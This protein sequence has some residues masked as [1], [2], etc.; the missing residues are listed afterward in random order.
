MYILRNNYVSFRLSD[1]LLSR[2]KSISKLTQRNSLSVPFPYN[3]I[4]TVSPVT[5]LIGKLMINL[6]TVKN[7]FRSC[8]F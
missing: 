4:K 1:I 8:L 5:E 3:S 7:H 2:F 6:V